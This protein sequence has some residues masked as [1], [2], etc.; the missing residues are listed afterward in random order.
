MP[1][2]TGQQIV[3]ALI[4][5][6]Y[7]PFQAAALAGHALR[8]SGG[9]TDAV[10]DKEG[11]HGLWQFRLDRWDNLQNF[12]K[13]QGKD[14]TDPDVQLDFVGREMQGPEK[15]SSEAFR[16]STDVASASDALRKYIRFGDDSAGTRLNNSVGL[17]KSYDPSAPIAAGAPIDA[18]PTI[19][20]GAAPSPT[21][22]MS[23]A[24]VGALQGSTPAAPQS[25]VD[26]LASAL[27]GPAQPQGQAAQQP[28]QPEYLPE[29]QIQTA[30]PNGN[31]L[32]IAQALAKL[33]G[34]G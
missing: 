14:P 30:K 7:Q 4:D 23:P 22:I 12:A 6:G 8:E 11:A 34:M 2:L 16:N 9:R 5:R 29:Q 19:G 21:N 33:Y 13:S 28:Q 27:S 17:L 32:A 20:P 1:S 18:A 15:K 31:S 24:Q 3:R 10:N 26:K 25:P